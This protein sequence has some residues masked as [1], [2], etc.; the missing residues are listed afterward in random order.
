[1]KYCT[2]I[3][4]LQ[5]YLHIFEEDMKNRKQVETSFGLQNVSSGYQIKSIHLLEG[6]AKIEVY[7]KDR[8][9]KEKDEYLRGGDE[10]YFTIKDGKVYS[11]KEW[12]DHCEEQEKD[13][14]NIDR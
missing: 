4:E 6:F 13:D 14:V 11:Y 3:N 9:F 1:M 12:E 7:M 10:A 8:K 5:D 2:N